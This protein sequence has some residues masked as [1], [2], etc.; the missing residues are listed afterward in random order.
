MITQAELIAQPSACESHQFNRQVLYRFA[1]QLKHLEGDS[2]NERFE[3][4]SQREQTK[5]EALRA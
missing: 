2:I 4:G 5:A 3:S 1:F